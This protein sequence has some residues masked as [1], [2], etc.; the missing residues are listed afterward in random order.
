MRDGPG[1]QTRIK[2]PKKNIWNGFNIPTLSISGKM[3][4]APDE[5]VPTVATVGHIR[6]GKVWRRIGTN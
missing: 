5:V 3:S 4:T 6:S 1:L 2:E